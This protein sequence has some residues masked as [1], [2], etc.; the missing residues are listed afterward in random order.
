MAH[1]VGLNKLCRII[2][3]TQNNASEESTPEK[4]RSRLSNQFMTTKQVEKLVP[5]KTTSNNLLQ[6]DEVNIEESRF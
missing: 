6:V 3:N 2:S 1:N 5:K 4:S